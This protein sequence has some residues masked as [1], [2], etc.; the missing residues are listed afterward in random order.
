MHI[1]EDVVRKALRALAA[2]LEPAVKKRVL[3]AGA[4]SG[5][6]LTFDGLT[7]QEIPTV[8]TD[9]DREFAMPEGM[10]DGELIPEGVRR[11]YNRGLAHYGQTDMLLPEHNMAKLVRAHEWLWVKAGKPTGK[12]VKERKKP[13]PR[14]ETVRDY[15]WRG[16]PCTKAQFEQRVR[17]SKGGIPENSGPVVVQAV[18]PKAKAKKKKG[19]KAKPVVMDDSL[20]EAMR[21][22]GLDPKMLD[23]LKVLA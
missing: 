20:G 16:E 17:M 7:A 8:F 6:G 21:V 19:K 14:P 4:A 18:E 23:A 22:L 11:R 3:V 13:E 1:S 12:P 9:G 10:A 15:T 2:D 5:V